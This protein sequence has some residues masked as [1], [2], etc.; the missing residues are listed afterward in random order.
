MSPGRPWAWPRGTVRGRRR[1]SAGGPALP[2]LRRDAARRGAE[3]RG[4]L[5]RTRA[6]GRLRPRGTEVWPD[7]LH[8]RDVRPRHAALAGAAELSE[9]PVL[10]AVR[11]LFAGG[12]AP[13]HRCDS[14]LRRRP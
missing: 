4:G 14:L 2:D 9:V 1:A 6:A 7:V 8:L 10:D 3:C 5:D 11:C 13:A 12:V